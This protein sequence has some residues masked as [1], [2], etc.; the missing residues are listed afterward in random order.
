MDQHYTKETLYRLRN[1]IPIATLIGDILDI[2]TKTQDGHLRFLCPI[3]SEFMTACNPKT[4]L[5]RCFRCEQKKYMG[6]GCL[7]L[8][9][10]LPSGKFQLSDM[11]T[12]LGEVFISRFALFQFS[13]NP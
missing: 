10:F 13:H 12:H 11:R 3:C 5:A 7:L 1:K 4:N 6:T 9:R 2:S 8:T